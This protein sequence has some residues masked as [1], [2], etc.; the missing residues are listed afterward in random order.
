MASEA[1]QLC[2]G[3]LLDAIEDTS[4]VYIANDMTE[5]AAKNKLESSIKDPNKTKDLDRNSDIPNFAISTASK[6]AFNTKLHKLEKSSNE[7]EVNI[8]A[9]N[10]NNIF[11]C[12]V[13]LKTRS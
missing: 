10:T 7:T 12:N 3:I 4:M 2:V 11:A 9:L 8:R 5:T 1:Q 6:V 13:G